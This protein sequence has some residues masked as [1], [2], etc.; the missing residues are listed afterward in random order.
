MLPVSEHVRLLF[1][2]GEGSVVFLERRQP[3]EEIG[4]FEALLGKPF[5]RG[6]RFPGRRGIP[7]RE[8]QIGELFARCD[9]GRIALDRGVPGAP[10]SFDIA[11]A[12]E[13]LA[14]EVVGDGGGAGGEAPLKKWDRFGV[15][16]LIEQ[17][18]AMLLEELLWRQLQAEAIGGQRLGTLV[19][20][21]R[22]V[23]IAAVGLNRADENVAPGSLARQ[24]GEPLGAL[25]G[26]REE[27]DA[28]AAGE[29][30]GGTAGMVG[31]RSGRRRGAPNAWSI[32]ASRRSIVLCRRSPAEDSYASRRPPRAPASRRR[33]RG[34]DCR[35]ARRANGS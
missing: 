1:P 33:R 21:E 28:R 31:G 30:D 18:R 12:G 22:F 34:G 17:E 24:G 9:A 32:I 4:R 25:D 11:G 14:E 8:R 10:G 3:L 19:G 23:G 27:P 2:G 16:A 15:A 20:E 7:G 35:L 5:Q 26:F 13:G 29:A 6:D